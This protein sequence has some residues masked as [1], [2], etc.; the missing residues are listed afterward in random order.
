MSP[1]PMISVIMPV[2]NSEQFL[3]PAIQSVLNQSFKDF[4]LIIVDDGSKDRSFEI[5]ESFRR[6]DSRIRLIK[7]SHNQRVANVSNIALQG[8]GGKYI[9]RMD[10]DDISLPER[11]SKQVDFME[12]H[13]DIGIL[14]CG[15]QHMD[16][17]GQLLSVPPLFQGDLSIHWHFMFESPFFNPTVMIRRSVLDQYNLKYDPLSVYGED[18]ELWSRLLPLT[19]G[20]NLMDVLLYYRLHPDSITHRYNYIDSKQEMVVNVAAHAVK[21]YLPDLSVSKQ[22]VIDLQRAIWGVSNADKNRRANLLPLYFE[23]W[24]AFCSKNHGNP[25]LSLLEKEV[26][27]WA[28]RMLLYPPFQSGS[29][30]QFLLLTNKNWKWPIF[31]FGHLSYFLSRRLR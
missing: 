28:A 18:Y 9:A 23:I 5:A 27:A 13:L 2:F 19:K 1:R 26:F 24:D 12:S 31:L 4:E 16:V 11:F 25:E 21:A 10:A 6:I 15:M 3:R 22:E 7:L 29:V 14:G 8:A 20:E 30:R 17:N